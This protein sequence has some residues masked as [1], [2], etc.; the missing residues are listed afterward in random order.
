MLEC[1]LETLACWGLCVGPSKLGRPLKYRGN[2]FEAMRLAQQRHWLA[3]GR[4]RQTPIGPRCGRWTDWW[5]E[6]PSLMLRHLARIR[7]TRWLPDKR[8][9]GTKQ[10]ENGCPKTGRNRHR[11]QRGTT[12][13]LCDKDFADFVGELSDVISLKTLVSLGRELFGALRAVFWALCV[14]F[15]PFAP[16]RPLKKSENK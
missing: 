3:Q 16:D 5:L 8:A 4:R 10:G 1:V 14:L 12:K 13:K 7:E 6:L 2:S 11:H 9:K 15:E